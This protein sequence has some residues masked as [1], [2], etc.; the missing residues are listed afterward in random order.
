MADPSTSPATE[1]KVTVQTIENTNT[2]RDI[3]GVDKSWGWRRTM[4]FSV[5]WAC[6][7]IL[8]WIMLRRP[9]SDPIIAMYV[10]YSFYTMWLGL[11][12]Y[13]AQSSVSELAEAAGI[14]FSGRRK[15]LTTAPK[16]AVVETTPNDIG[17]TSV[18]VASGET[19]APIVAEAT[20]DSVRADAGV[21]ASNTPPPPR[22]AGLDMEDA[23]WAKK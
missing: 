15:L 16:A 14:F 19:V 4:Y 12:L 9:I 13:G 11:C 10:K 22:P 7:L 2:P 8:A 23:P 21:A 5:V 17:G 6:T 18:K 1:E 3:R 20:A